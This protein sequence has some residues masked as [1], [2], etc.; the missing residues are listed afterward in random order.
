MQI[1]FQSRG[2]HCCNSVK[3]RS[4][5]DKKSRSDQKNVPCCNSAKKI[6]QMTERNLRN[7]KKIALDVTRQKNIPRQVRSK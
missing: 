1:R 3:N 2:L 6:A 7:Q 5:Y 4:A